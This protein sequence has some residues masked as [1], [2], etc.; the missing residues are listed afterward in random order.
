MD[1]Q[2]HLL[3][4]KSYLIFEKG[5]SSNT[6]L[7]YIRDVEFFINFANE[8]GWEI[9]RISLENIESYLQSIN[10]KGSAKSSLA[11][12]IS[13]IRSFFDFLMLYDKISTS[14]MDIIETP[15]ISRKIPDI[16]SEE[17]VEKIICSIKLD[18]W[19]GYRNKAIIETL[20][21][22]GLRVSELV[23]VRISDLFFEDG[24]L[25]V[26]GKGSK[27][28][29]VP[30]SQSM[31]DSTNQ[32]IEVRRSRKLSS[33]I[34][35]INNRSKKLSREMI[36]MIIKKIVKDAGITKSISPHTFRHSFATALIKG[37]ADIRV[38]Q[39]MLGHESILTTEIYTHLDTRHKRGVVEE[40]HPLSKR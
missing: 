12:N 23:G 8:N 1:W 24:F 4:Y 26:F 16:L 32:Y 21:S 7:A 22:C 31:I 40:Y 19:I 30:V 17:E 5:V 34:L 11:R 39:D 18:K 20:Y 35:F 13:G 38:V 2:E 29:L 6:S 36:F 37:G 28:R 15:K 14:V 9:D 33:D 10:E 25:R 27:E 3:E